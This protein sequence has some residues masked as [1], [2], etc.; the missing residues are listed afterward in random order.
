MEKLI[1]TLESFDGHNA[2]NENE[3]IAKFKTISDANIN[4]GYFLINDTARIRSLSTTTI[5]SRLLNW[6]CYYMALQRVSF[7]KII[8][9]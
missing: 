6:Q 4:G 7:T 1:N 8:S 2:K 5:C 9:L 3:L